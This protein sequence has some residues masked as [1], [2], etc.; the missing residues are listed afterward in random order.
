MIWIDIR[1]AKTEQTPGSKVRLTASR[2]SPA[3]LVLTFQLSLR[4]KPKLNIASRG[5]T[6]LYPDFVGA[7]ADVVAF[8][9]LLRGHVEFGRQFR[10][11]PHCGG[12]A[13]LPPQPS[14]E[15]G[16]L[17]KFACSLH[18]DTSGTGTELSGRGCGV[19][20]LNERCG[21]PEGYESRH[22]R[23]DPAQSARVHE[24]ENPD[25]GEAR[26]LGQFVAFRPRVCRA[27]Q[28]LLRGRC[29]PQ[30]HHPAVAALSARI[31]LATVV[32]SISALMLGTITVT[33]RGHAGAKG[34]PGQRH[35]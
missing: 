12:I 9:N 33:V 5:I 4:G 13:D 21:S 27:L 10:D 19:H 28:L 16:S 14:I 31:H 35:Q 23:L 32:T 25:G 2:L 15:F 34:E 1:P 8:L 22:M 6:T 3:E 11:R 20:P 18:L 17:T 29:L 26:R 7:L 30:A 24:L